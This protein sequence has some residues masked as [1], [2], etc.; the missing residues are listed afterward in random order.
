VGEG[1]HAVGVE[2]RQPISGRRHVEQVVAN[3]RALVVGREPQQRRVPAAK[4]D[5]RVVEE[6]EDS[7][8]VDLRGAAVAP[9]VDDLAVAGS[10]RLDQQIAVDEGLAVARM[11]HEHVAVFGVDQVELSV[12]S[13]DPVV[14]DDQT[15]RAILQVVAARART[16]R[17]EAVRLVHDADRRRVGVVLEPAAEVAVAVDPVALDPDVPRVAVEGADEEPVTGVGEDA[18]ADHQVLRAL[19]VDGCGVVRVGPYRAVIVR[20]RV[21]GVRGADV[22]TLDLDVGRQ[23]VRGHVRGA[24]L[25]H[26]ALI[27]G[28][29]ERIGRGGAVTGHDRP[30]ASRPGNAAHD[31]RRRSRSR[32]S[33][34][35]LLPVGLGPPVDP[36]LVARRERCPRNVADRSQ[37][38]A[39]THQVDRGA[40]RAGGECGGEEQRGGRASDETLGLP[41]HVEVGYGGFAPRPVIE[42]TLQMKDARLFASATQRNRGPILGVLRRVLPRSGALLEIASG[43]G[44]HAVWFAEQLPGFVLQPSDPSPEHRASI[45]AWIGT[46][47]LP[48][49]RAPLALDVTSED[50]EADPQ[51]PRDLTAILCINLIHIAPWAAALGLLRGAGAALAPGRLLYLYGPYRRGGAHT[52]PSNAA[53]DRSLRA[54]DPA[55]GVR[56]LEAVLTASE[57]A[58]FALDEVVEMPANNLSVI[59]KRD[60]LTAS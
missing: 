42:V 16:Q 52:A 11:V 25:D 41:P 43:T 15:R 14:A 44:E 48:N 40:R 28:E 46:S 36:H 4:R 10:V 6:V 35:P 32:A 23:R 27:V 30:L 39:G 29:V 3:V 58:G 24:D 57:E 22:Q 60:P 37:R 26:A 1:E 19:H 8:A 51:I 21:G 55:W 17:P 33:D 38:M 49:L 5:D 18:V 34:H 31:D 20:E 47:G 7:L 45:G 53:F 9:I 2:H 59:L 54:Q 13:L 12:A 56:D 50:W